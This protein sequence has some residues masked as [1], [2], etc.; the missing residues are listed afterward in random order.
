MKLDKMALIFNSSS[1]CID[2]D[3]GLNRFGVNHS[4]FPVLQAT[5][6]HPRYFPTTP[7]ENLFHRPPERS[8][9]PRLAT[10]SVNSCRRVHKTGGVNPGRPPHMLGASVARQLRNVLTVSDGVTFITVSRDEWMRCARLTENNFGKSRCLLGPDRDKMIH[11]ANIFNKPSRAAN[12][13]DALPSVVI[14]S[15]LRKRSL[16]SLAC[17]AASFGRGLLS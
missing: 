2:F 14:P 3:T 17:S 11:I 4:T 16:Y 5:K 6:P 10:S 13:Y 7:L 8:D 1:S 12:A 9:C 15:D